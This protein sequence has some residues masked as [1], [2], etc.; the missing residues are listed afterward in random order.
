MAAPKKATHVITHRKQYMA[1]GG[2][3]QHV[4]EGTEVALSVEQG[5]RMVKRGRVLA[6]G[7]KKSVDLTGATDTDA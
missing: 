6:I 5:N 7:Q 2:K 3:L 1:V 4:P